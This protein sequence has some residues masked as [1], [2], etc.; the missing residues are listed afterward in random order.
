MP[1][2]LE[3]TGGSDSSYNTKGLRYNGRGKT[4]T[5]L[6]TLFKWDPAIF[7]QGKAALLRVRCQIRLYNMSEKVED[8]LI[9]TE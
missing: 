2:N 8:P 7:C 6:I 3:F 4:R 1:N 9:E 5:L